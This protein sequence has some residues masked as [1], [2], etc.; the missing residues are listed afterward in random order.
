MRYV[1]LGRGGLADDN[2]TEGFT[3]TQPGWFAI[4]VGVMDIVLN[5]DGKNTT[6]L[7]LPVGVGGE[8]C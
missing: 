3:L 6:V 5:Y 1:A 4:R 2:G 7:A 8:E